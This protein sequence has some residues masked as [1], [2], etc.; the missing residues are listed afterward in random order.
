M[1][2]WHTVRFDGQR[3]KELRLERR[4]DQH[5]L[6]SEARKHSTGIT[7]PQI[8]RY[9][10]VDKPVEPSGRNA[11]AL[12]RA[13]GIEVTELYAG[14]SDSNDA[15]DGLTA[16]PLDDYLRSRIRQIVR[17]ERQQLLEGARR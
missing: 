15:D 2:E 7:Q 8:S 9:E 12:A 13:L 1:S 5:R 14:D 11:L 16:L 17:E 3:L 6:A 10:N 4:W